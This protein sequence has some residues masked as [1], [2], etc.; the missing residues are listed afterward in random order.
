MND[1]KS[2]LGIVLFGSLIGLSEL[3]F[4]SASLPY[5]AV[6]MNA[7]AIGLLLFA[8]VLWPNKGTSLMIIAVAVAFKLGNLGIFMCKPAA[9]VLLGVAFEAFASLLTNK[10]HLSRYLI[11]AALTAA[12]AFPV[13]A[14]FETFIVR[15]TYWDMA[16]FVDYGVIKGALT[17][18]ASVILGSLSVL[19]ARQ[20]SK[21][22]S[23]NTAWAQT[24]L[25]LLIIAAWAVGTIIPK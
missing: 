22:T 12:T 25:S 24:L 9:L 21:N 8:R 4:G 18:A 1:K 20:F 6:F 19:A 15:N 17:M 16:R 7:I 3:F 23:L 14:A 11:T 13:F 2:F 10:Q 5:R